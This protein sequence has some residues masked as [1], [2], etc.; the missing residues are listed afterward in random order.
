MNPSSTLEAT[1]LSALRAFGLGLL[2]LG[3]LPQLRAEQFGLFTYQRVEDAVEITSYPRDAVGPVEIP[4]SITGLPVTRVGSY[5]FSGCTGLTSVLL[6]QGLTS[7]GE[8][9]FQGCSR[10][11]NMVIPSG[12]TNIGREAFSTCSGLTS[13]HLPSSVTRIGY[14]AFSGCIALTAIHVGAGSPAY[15][16]D[17]GVLLNAE[18]TELI[19]CPPGRQ[20]DYTI[21]ASV[22]SIGYNAFSDGT[23]LTDIH[24]ET[25]NRV[26]ASEGGA[27]LNAKR[28]ELILCPTGKTGHYSIVSGVASIGWQAFQGCSLLTNVTM[29]EGI[30]N[31]GTSAFSGCT[32][33]TSMAIPSGV[34]NIGASAFS[35]CTGLTSVTLP[36]SLLG[37]GDEAFSGCT[38]LTAIHVEVGT[39]A[40]ASE[41][42]VLLNAERTRLIRYPEGKAGPYTL[43]LSVTGIGHKAFG[44]CTGLTA[45]HVEAGNPAYA[46]ED[47]V[48]LDAARTKLIRYPP[49]KAGAYILPSS[50]TGIGGLNYEE[51]VTMGGAFSGCTGL[52]SVI[53]PASVTQIG[54]VYASRGG[55]YNYPAFSGCTALTRATFL[56]NAP[57]MAEGEFDHAAPGFTIHFLSSHQGF[58]SPTWDPNPWGPRP[59]N[60][61]TLRIDEAT[62]PAA[63]WLLTHGLGYD[64]QLN[65]D[66]DGD[67][68]NLLTAYAL[69]LDPRLNLQGRLPAPALGE[70]SL[71]LSFHASSPGITYR[72]ETST[73]LAEWSTTGVT[74][75][76]PGADGR[77]TATVPRDEPH[78]FL[79]LVFED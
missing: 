41:D 67:G 15:A 13:I 63:S 34:T 6:E 53:I 38:A 79:R 60:L 54:W 71:S 4:A 2:L 14:D 24:V 22:I 26:Y 66:P 25:G 21:P 76:A 64:S 68:V 48:L 27:L 50:I 75:S 45:I 74:Q 7:I 32:G 36:S 47:G 1:R 35:G 43:P 17:G 51:V 18:Q 16:S 19:R 8:T 46:S 5:A 31:I 77:S 11:T 29:P 78:R 28:T 20:G 42:G 44:G 23:R 9:A 61:P 40:Y 56:G 30:T 72:V 57:A 69:N 59:E 55:F 33:L 73:N 58:T 65:E 52:T 12:V 3:F 10:L 70:D 49:G 37:I 39:G 62:Y